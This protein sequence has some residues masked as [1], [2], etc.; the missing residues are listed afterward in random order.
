MHSKDYEDYSKRDHNGSGGNSSSHTRGDGAIAG[1]DGLHWQKFDPAEQ[2]HLSQE[3]QGANN[4]G[5]SPRQLDV[6][7]HPLVW[8]LLHRVEVVDVADSLYVGQNAG[9][10]H[11]GEEVN[12]HEHGGAGAEGDEESRRVRIGGV[13]LHFHHRHLTQKEEMM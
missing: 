1:L 2:N 13:Q 9:T 11:Q 10:D 5:E 4:R 8:R 3:E 6:S 12:S 7:V